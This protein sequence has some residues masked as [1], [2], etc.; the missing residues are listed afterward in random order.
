M[1]KSMSL[2][3]IPFSVW[4]PRLYRWTAGAE[5]NAFVP[6]SASW[7]CILS[8]IYL[9]F[10][11]PWIGW[12]MGYALKLWT[13]INSFSIKQRFLGHFIT[14]IEK[15][16]KGNMHVWYYRRYSSTVINRKVERNK[17]NK[18]CLDFLTRDKVNIN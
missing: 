5:W 15:E 16:G 3:G 13:R 10:L 6:P 12:Q 14:T 1:W 9:T 17:F 8:L 18:Q 11:S 7:F 2:C 4:D